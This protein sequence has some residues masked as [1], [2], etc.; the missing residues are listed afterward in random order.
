MEDLHIGHSFKID[1]DLLHVEFVPGRQDRAQVIRRAG[2]VCVA[3]P[4][5]FHADVPADR[6]WLCKA[7]EAVVREEARSILPLRLAALAARHGLRYKAVRI[8][9]TR[10]RWGSC[11]S[12]G[13]INLSLWLML[14]PERLVDYV[15]QHELAHLREMNHGPRFWQELDRMTGG[16]ARLLEKE[17]RDFARS[18]MPR[19][20]RLTGHDRG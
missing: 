12:L 19:M 14:A 8:K 20:L 4:A 13:N 3:L 11:S 15:L 7:F 1:T 5:G 18:Q 2:K 9:N 10:S 17:M 6:A 16:K